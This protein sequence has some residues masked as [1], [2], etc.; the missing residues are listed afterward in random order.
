MRPDR[1]VVVAPYAAERHEL[2]QLIRAE[3]QIEGKLAS[4]NHS[5]PIL[6]EQKFPNPHIAGNYRPDVEIHFRTGD[7][8]TV[9]RIEPVHSVRLDNGKTVDLD[10]ETARHIDYGEAAQLAGLED[11][12]ARLNPASAN[13]PSTGR[14]YAGISNG[15]CAAARGG[16]SVVKSLLLRLRILVSRSLHS[17]RPSSRKSACISKQGLRSLWRY[18]GSSKSPIKR[19]SSS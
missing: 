1:T 2:T 7:F 18:S 10:S 9:E 14:C 12:L 16:R 17:Q 5:L 11:D 19:R 13:L 15:I 4:E 6:V 3:L 8:A